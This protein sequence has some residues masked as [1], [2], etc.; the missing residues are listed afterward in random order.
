VKKITF[1]RFAVPLALSVLVLAGCG[2]DGSSPSADTEQA[3]S[4]AEETSDMSAT[5]E[6]TSAEDLSEEM[7]A[8]TALL[9][10]V[11]SNPLTEGDISESEAE[12]IV[13]TIAAED[14]EL[15]DMMVASET[16]DLPD[17]DADDALNVLE[18]SAECTRDSVS[19][20]MQSEN[21]LS[22]DQAECLF[23]EIYGPDSVTMG[24]I[25]LAA[26]MELMGVSEDEPEF[27][28]AATEM[29]MV[30]M[31]EPSRIAGVCGLD[32]SV[33]ST[34]LENSGADGVDTEDDMDY[35]DPY[36]DD[37]VDLGEID[38][39]SLDADVSP[40]QIMC[41]MEE[42]QVHPELLETLLATGEVNTDNPADL[43]ILLEAGMAC[44]ISGF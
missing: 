39:D 14:P 32:E 5:S 30:L 44:G 21:S 29:M 12:C 13:D 9:L 16:G 25:A 41:M 38:I 2:G 28:E 3:S 27:V 1:Q 34:V 6:E 26:E 11:D 24:F 23:D 4:P 8:R 15:F 31:G 20:L 7:D 43:M 33:V 42:L 36:L 10:S 17:L 37:G 35:V 19:T 18:I 22:A 40:E